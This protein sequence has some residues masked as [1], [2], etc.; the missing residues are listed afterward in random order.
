LKGSKLKYSGGRRQKGRWKISGVSNLLKW[1]E[2]D[3]E[4]RIIKM[5]INKVVGSFDVAVKDFFDGATVLI[6]GFGT[7][8]GCPSYLMEA[9]GRQGAKD[10]TIVCNNVGFGKELMQVVAMFMKVPDW[11]Y[12]GGELTNNRQVK[13]A[14]AA[15]PVLASP[16][17]V[18]PFEKQLRAGEVE[19]DI[20]PQGTLA[21]RIRAAKAGI[22]AFY[23][24]VGPGTIVE[25]GKEVRVIDGRKH[26]LEYPIKADFG[27]IRAYKADRLGN[28]IYRG[29]SRTFNATMAGAA[30]VTIA[31]VDEV[32]EVG[33]LDPESIVTPALYVDR[34][35]V[36][37]EE[38][39]TQIVQKISKEEQLRN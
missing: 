8:G 13:K 35:A 20:V 26:V 33:E 27:L 15:F 19:I 30:K 28:L 37:P 9:L 39:R 17:L 18:S 21:E 38:G 32:V 31:E 34:V 1:A 7:P 5:P 10:L 16:L 11:W 22:G 29:T 6:G 4:R 36:R 12:D 3:R 23:C 14:I 2:S 25:K 24:P